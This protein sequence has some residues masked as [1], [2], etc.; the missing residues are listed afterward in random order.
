MQAY[1]DKKM[2][3]LGF[4]IQSRLVPKLVQAIRLAYLK[5]TCGFPAEYAFRLK[6]PTELYSFT[7]LPLPL[8]FFFCLR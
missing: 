7:F 1:R 4:T 8:H 2:R 6:A 5:I 3:L